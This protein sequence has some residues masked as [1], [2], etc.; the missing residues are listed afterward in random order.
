MPV[1]RAPIMAPFDPNADANLLVHRLGCV[2]RQCREMADANISERVVLHETSTISSFGL[3]AGGPFA[4]SFD[5][6]RMPQD[7]SSSSPGK[8]L[9]LQSERRVPGR[10]LQGQRAAK[11]E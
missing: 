9:R 8:S 11:H 3:G 4:T 1:G 2:A 10:T 7:E 6:C 5:I